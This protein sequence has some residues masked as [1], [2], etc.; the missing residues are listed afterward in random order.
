MQYR[1]K[2]KLYL[3]S[4]IK[5]WLILFFALMLIILNDVITCKAQNGLEIGGNIGASYYMGELNPGKHFYSPH[6][7][8][9]GFIKYHFDKRNIVKAGLLTTSLSADDKDFDNG[10]Q[11]LRNHSFKTSL[12]EISATYEVN[13][14]PYSFTNKNKDSFTP[15]SSLGVALFFAN[16]LSDKVSV[17]IPITVGIKKNIFPRFILGIEWSFR[18]TFTDDL[19][20]VSGEDLSIYSIYTETLA[21]NTTKQ[22][23]FR[24][25]KDWYSIACITLSYT[26]KLG[27]ISCNAY[28][29]NKQ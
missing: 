14:L 10:F 2:L 7:N 19:D 17:A 15:Y 11:Q 22:T 24:Y 4:K 12:V 21:T 13:F 16:S 23:G 27:G 28:Y 26:F 20:N 8:V 6:I 18:K 3:K 1:C 5:N 25:T 29:N 9:G